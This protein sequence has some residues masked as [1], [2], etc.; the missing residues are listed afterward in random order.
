[1]MHIKT[2]LAC[3]ALTA[4]A[5]GCGQTGRT[6][7]LS[8]HFR[9]CT[10]HANALPSAERG[11]NQRLSDVM[12]AAAGSVFS[13]NASMWTETLGNEEGTGHNSTSVPVDIDVPLNQNKASGAGSA[14][15]SVADKALGLLKSKGDGAEKKTDPPDC[16][17]GSCD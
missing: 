17:D 11:E 3:G 7:T 8:Q 9:E 13:Q 10:I 16:A 12:D 4:L 15:G 5:T 14:A 6:I 2:L 1:M